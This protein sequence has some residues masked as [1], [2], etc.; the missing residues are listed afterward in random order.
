MK[1]WVANGQQERQMMMKSKWLKRGMW[2]LVWMVTLGSL[3]YAEENWRGARAWKTYE[4]ELRAKGEP[5]TIQEMLPERPPDELNM[6][7]APVF[8]GMFEFKKEWSDRFKRNMLYEAHPEVAKRNEAIALPGKLTSGIDPCLGQGAD[9]KKIREACEKEIRETS[10]KV[11]VTSAIPSTLADGPYLLEVMRQRAELY[12]QV[13]E[14][15][16]RPQV[17]WPIPYE[18]G[19]FAQIPQVGSLLAFAKA[20]TLRGVASLDADKPGEAYRDWLVAQQLAESQ[21]GQPVLVSYMVGMT[22]ESISMQVVWE[23]LRRGAW[24][25][26]ELRDIEARLAK[27]NTA[28]DIQH[29]L[30]GERATMLAVLSETKYLDLISL[31]SSGEADS[32]NPGAFLGIA[33]SA[34]RPR[35]WLDLEK[36]EYARLLQDYLISGLV[37]PSG[38]YNVA[39]FEENS[40][41]VKKSGHSWLDSF[42]KPMLYMVFP[43]LASI[44]SQSAHSEAKNRQGILACALERYRQA[45]GSYPERLD[46]LDVDPRFRLD[47]VTDGDMVYRLENG[48]YIIY[49]V[50]WNLKDDGGAYDPKK[51]NDGDWPWRMPFGADAGG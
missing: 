28:L 13:E 10:A 45:H 42:Q 16:A 25:N 31:I 18:E 47:P 32:G 30:R 19:I 22:I 26:A 20:F 51:K 14:A 34:L 37:S 2:T 29:S 8:A 40:K 49:S 12:R 4:S 5:L 44:V 39:Q 21:S 41:K 35:G 6:A 38:R 11:P 15:V 24:S 50:G 48:G 43:A 36:R 17:Y 1:D 33:L 27:K 9:L 7:M 46:Q 3:F 23:G